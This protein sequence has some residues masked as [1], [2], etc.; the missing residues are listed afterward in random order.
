M[1]A[2]WL[3]TVV[4]GIVIVLTWLNQ[5]FIEQGIPKNQKEWIA[6]LTGNAAGLIGLFAKSYNVSNSGTNAPAHIVTAPTAS[7]ALG[8]APPKVP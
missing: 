6:F 5:I 7:P 3:T 1:G 2:S 8:S 4:G